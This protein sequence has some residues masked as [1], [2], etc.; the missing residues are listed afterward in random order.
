MGGNRHSRAG[1]PTGVRAGR[2]RGARA[3]DRRVKRP[4]VTTVR[5][6]SRKLAGLEYAMRLSDDVAPFNVVCVLR[7]KGSL[8]VQTLRAAL[9]ELQRRHR[10]LRAR[11]V[12]EARIISSISTSRSRLRSTSWSGPA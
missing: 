12:T 2:D 4:P 9:D 3:L 1:V 11:I 6:D 7:I 5:G 8:P 10:F